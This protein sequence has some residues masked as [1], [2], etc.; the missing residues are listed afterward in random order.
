MTILGR[1]EAQLQ[2]QSLPYQVCDVTDA[3]AVRAAFEAARKKSGPI[4]GVVANAGAAESAPF[5]RTDIEAFRSMMEVNLLGVVNVWQAA[6]SDMKAAEWGRMIAIAS[7]AGLK[8]YSYVSAY[9]AAK[10][11]VV[12]LTRALAQELAMT[13]ITVNAICPGFIDTPMLDRS[14]DN[15]VAKTRMSGDKARLS[16]AS[17]NPQNRF[18]QPTEVAQT[19]LWLFSEAAKSVNGHALALSGG[20]V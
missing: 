6:L 10:H 14:I 17:V 11:A 2:T 5:Q 12:G 19:A 3:A 20:E 8:G 15:I 1:R 13:G 7:T 9:C 4:V 18:I 16:L